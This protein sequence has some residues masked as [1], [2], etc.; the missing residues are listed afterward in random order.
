MSSMWLGL[1]SL[2]VGVG[3]SLYG[4]SQQKKAIESANTSNQAAS[5]KQNDS[6]WAGFLLGKG[7][8]PTTP[9]QAGVMP[10]AGN[11]TAVNTRMPLW[12]SMNTPTG[13]SRWQ[14]IG[15]STPAAG[16][17]AITKFATVPTSTT[18]ASSTTPTSIGTGQKLANILDPL[19]VAI[20]N[21]RNNFLD[22]LGVFCWAAREAYGE[23][24]PKWLR[25]RSW[26]LNTAPKELKDLYV[27]NAPALAE[28]MKADPVLKN[29][30]RR[31]MDGILT[32]G[33]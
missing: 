18:T 3:T 21:N 19:N 25:F 16:T 15:G 7:V 12:S 29:K 23:D 13:K 8:A 1:G 30:V 31:I 22:P 26:V 27:R 33:T 11:F 4:A 5:D 6:A 20:G 24:N 14:K 17:L 28:R 32:E 9:V 2:A 10:S